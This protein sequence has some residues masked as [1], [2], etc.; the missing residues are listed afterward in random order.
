MAA[1]LNLEALAKAKAALQKQKELSERLKRLPQVSGALSLPSTKA[2]P[3][4]FSI[5]VRAEMLLY[6][7]H[8]FAFSGLEKGD[9]PFKTVC[10]RIEGDEFASL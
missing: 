9:A 6:M 3:D 1:P 4:V 10:Y 8:Y 7:F 2:Y 5:R